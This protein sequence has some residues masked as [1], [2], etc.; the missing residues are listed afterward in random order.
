MQHYSIVAFFGSPPFLCRHIRER[1]SI[2]IT[3]IQDGKHSKLTNQF[4]VHTFQFASAS[5]S[6]ETQ[7]SQVSG[8]LLYCRLVGWAALSRVH[9]TF[10][11]RFCPC[12]RLYPL[13]FRDCSLYSTPLMSAH[14][15]WV[16]FYYTAPSFR[17]DQHSI[18]SISKGMQVFPLI[19]V[20]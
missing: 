3:R 8:A 20:R 18:S 15:R 4:S 9:V 5:C 11:N 1:A 2:C 14:H 13:P 6:L 16:P 17:D 10:F 12:K 19:N 7:A